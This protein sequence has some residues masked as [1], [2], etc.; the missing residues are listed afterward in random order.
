MWLTEKLDWKGL[1]HCSFSKGISIK[2]PDLRRCRGH[3]SFVCS[4]T[5][6]IQINHG[7]EF[8]NLQ[9]NSL[10]KVQIFSVKHIQFIVKHTFKATCFGS[11][12][13]S[14]DLFVRTDQYLITSTFRIPSVYNDGIFSV[15]YSAVYLV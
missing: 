4:S 6:T 13:P 12:E 10:Y 7:C 3:F 1:N 9:P 8:E 15:V 11:T 2:S 5:Y 14:S